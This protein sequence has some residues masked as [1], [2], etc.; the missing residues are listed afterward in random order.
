MV[1]AAEAGVGFNEGDLSTSFRI[2]W[3]QQGKPRLILARFVKHDDRI[4]LLCNKKKLKDTRFDK[5]MVGKRDLAPGC[6][7]LLRAVKEYSDTNNAWITG[8]RVINNLARFVRHDDRVRLLRNKEKENVA[9]ARREVGNEGNNCMWGW[10][11]RSPW[12]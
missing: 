6:A 10:E 7:R 5:V 1:V 9:E 4:R 11:V 3:Q 2:S 8:G 12:V